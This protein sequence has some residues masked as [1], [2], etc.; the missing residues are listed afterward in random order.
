MDVSGSEKVLV[1]PTLGFVD[2]RSLS[3]GMLAAVS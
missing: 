3:S 1:M 2:S